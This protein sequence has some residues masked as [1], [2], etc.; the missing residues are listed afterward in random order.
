M[1]M[2]PL[3]RRLTP[4]DTAYGDRPNGPRSNVRLPDATIASAFPS[5]VPISPL[6]RGNCPCRFPPRSLSLAIPSRSPYVPAH[7]AIAISR[8]PPV[9]SFAKRNSTRRSREARLVAYSALRVGRSLFTSGRK[10]LA[11]RYSDIRRGSCGI[12]SAG[13]ARVLRSWCV[14]VRDGGQ[15]LGHPQRVLRRRGGG[16]ARVW[17]P[18]C[19]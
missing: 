10:G 6:A 11:D 19:A 17:H 9:P 18:A 2:H 13:A 5:D 1:G 16:T 4:R 3:G 14:W 15:I 7:I 8:C 12:G